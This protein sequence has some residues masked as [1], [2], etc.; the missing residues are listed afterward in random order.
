MTTSTVSSALENELAKQWEGQWG[1]VCAKAAET[2]AT[3]ARLSGS[4]SLVNLI[5]QYLFGPTKGW[6]T[7]WT[8]ERGRE[9]IAF[10]VAKAETPLSFSSARL[11]VEYLRKR[12]VFGL[13]E[14]EKATGGKDELTALVGHYNPQ[15]PL[16][17]DIDD[18]MQTD[19]SLYFSK[20]YF[21]KVDDFGDLRD[22]DVRK[23]TDFYSLY[24][25][26]AGITAN[27]AEAIGKK[28]GLT[29]QHSRLK[30]DCI[31]RRVVA[32]HLNTPTPI[33][34]WIQFPLGGIGPSIRTFQGADFLVSSLGFEYPTIAEASFCMFFREAS[35]NEKIFR[36]MWRRDFARLKE[37][38][39]NN[40][41]GLRKGL[42]LQIGSFDRY[43]VSILII[44]DDPWCAGVAPTR[45]YG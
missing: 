19:L 22:Y 1:E 5:M 39:P 6:I 38:A 11:V 42:R 4:I 36:S 20:L 15:K 30:E 37:P 14:L 26:P 13:P 9:V 23:V 25:C 24:W 2:I 35:E 21:S 31:E 3:E 44:S 29:F 40:L 41:P 12:D 28:R 34:N 8:G 7:E 10:A 33:D 27:I 43:G 18:E 45:R 32:P 16:P 17:I